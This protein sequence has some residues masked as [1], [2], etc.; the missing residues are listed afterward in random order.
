MTVFR[1][2]GL[3]LLL[4]DVCDRRD[5]RRNQRYS[6]GMHPAVVVFVV[7]AAVAVAVVAVAAS[8]VAIAAAVVAGVAVVFASSVAAA[9]TETAE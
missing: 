1:F 4:A 3:L 9:T 6:N 2:R 8:S 7:A 5:Q